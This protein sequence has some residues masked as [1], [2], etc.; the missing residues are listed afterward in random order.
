[1]IILRKKEVERIEVKK[2]TL[3]FGRRKTGKT[4]LVENFIKSDQYFFINRD[5]TVISKND[6]VQ[7]TYDVFAERL[8]TGAKS[9]E[10][11]TI[12]EFHRLG[13]PFL[14][15]L[16][17]IGKG[18]KII[19]LT[20]TLFLAKRL[21]AARSPIMGLFNEVQIPIISLQ[22]TLEA[23]ADKKPIAIE[24]F[25]E[26]RNSKSMMNAILSGS[27]NAVPALFGEILIEEDK[28][29]SAIY[30]GIIR[31][32]ADGKVTSG[33]I[34]SSL[35][36]KRL[37]TKDDPSFVQSYLGVMVLIGLLK[38]IKVYNKN[39]FVYKIV[40]PLVRLFFYA[41]EK[42]GISQRQITEI[43]SE[44]IISEL[45]PHIVEDNI[46]EY[47]ADRLGLEE[48]VL[49]AGDYDIDG[50]LIKFKKP[51]VLLEVK[52]GKIDAKVI[53]KVE[54]NL[55]KIEGDSRI[56]FVNEKKGLS[57]SSIKIMDI[58]DLRKLS[59]RI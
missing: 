12:D 51:S 56:L 28:G 4:F 35:F 59:Q 5:R 55:G 10:T 42:Y 6:G 30:E 50:I 45:L 53:E 3:V 57:S 22:E 32:I 16:Q 40:S 46:R 1:M 48:A 15:L 17:S 38:R 39:K 7:I 54:Q 20:S 9:G 31:A 2:W 21:I 34:S 47:V 25:D 36:S 49:E 58:H 8:K 33:N 19:L 14:D 11:I 24:F 41:D 44:R 29:T 52:W 26:K 37:I 18:G 13:E 27:A 43:E 23:L